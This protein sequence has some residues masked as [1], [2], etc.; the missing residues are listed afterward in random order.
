MKLFNEESLADLL[1]HC[2]KN[3]RYRGI[4]LLCNDVRA[5]NFMTE[6]SKRFTDDG[7]TGVKEIKIND[8]YTYAPASKIGEIIFNNGSIISVVT[9]HYFSTNR[10]GARYHEPLLDPDVIDF[11]TIHA[12]EALTV[13]YLSPYMSFARIIHPDEQVRWS[14]ENPV[15]NSKLN[16]RFTANKEL[17]DFLNS[18][19]IC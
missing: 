18:F 3:R 11:D 5:H 7:I 19:K 17:D 8:A 13:V 1:S 14:I 10:I 6:I 12:L 4:I 9:P 15:D 16:D 2:Y